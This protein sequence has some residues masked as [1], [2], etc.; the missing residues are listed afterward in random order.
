MPT[1][2]PPKQRQLLEYL[3]RAISRAGKAP[4]LRKAAGDLG[5]SHAAVAQ[6]LNTLEEKGYIK[7]DGRY[8]RNIYVLNR[9]QQ[10]EGLQRWQEVPIIGRVTAGLPMYAQQAW[11]GSVV[12]DAHV[13]GRQQLFALR[14]KG[15]SMIAAGIYN[16][17]LA[18]CEPR[19]YAQNREIIVALI[20]GEEATVKR[21]FL[22]TD[23]IELRPENPRYAPMRYPFSAVLIQGKVIGIHRGPEVMEAV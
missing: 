22:H 16:G 2:L 1:E 11:D 5:V 15:D 20:H 21:F 23:H 6:G 14:I 10:P 8:S 17:D 7:R 19:Q 13:F 3:R 12:I 18:I 4:S 9:L